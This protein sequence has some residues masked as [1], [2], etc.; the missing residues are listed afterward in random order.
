MTIQHIGTRAMSVYIN[1]RELT[2]W[3]LEPARIGRDEALRLLSFALTEKRLG[4]WE[5]AELEIFSGHDAVLLFVRRKSGLPRHFWFSDFETLLHAVHAC[6]DALPSALSTVED[7]YLLTVYP[8]EGD[9][10]PAAFYEY[11]H[12]LGQSSYLSVHLEE[13]GASLLPSSAM[14]HLRFHFSY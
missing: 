4:A 1:E 6:P 10:P 12:E 2:A 13:Q 5:A 7:G 9:N 8:F 11:G 3:G 14:A